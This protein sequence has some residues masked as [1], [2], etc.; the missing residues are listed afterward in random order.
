MGL[1]TCCFRAFIYR[2]LPHYLLGKSCF[3]LV[4]F[5]CF[6]SI[7]LSASTWVPVFDDYWGSPG[8]WQDG[9]VPGIVGNELV[10]AIFPSPIPPIGS[11]VY[12]RQG[13]AA[14]DVGLSSIVFH[15]GYTLLPYLGNGQISAPAAGTLT[16][17]V[18]SQ[19]HP[20]INANMVFDS[21]QSLNL[22]IGNGSS[23]KL[24]GVS[25]LTNTSLS[26]TGSGELMITGSVENISGAL[27]ALTLDV[28]G[29]NIQVASSGMISCSNTNNNNANATLTIENSTLSLVDSGQLNCTT[30]FKQG[31]ALLHIASSDVSIAD[32][33]KISCN[34]V[35]SGGNTNVSLQIDNSTITMNDSSLIEVISGG[36]VG[37]V[38]I[39][40]NDSVLNINSGTISNTYNFV[41]D[42]NGL[43]SFNQSTLNVGTGVISCIGSENLGSG[44]EISFLDSSVSCTETL[45][46]TCNS[47]AAND[48][49]F[50]M[51]Q[52]TISIPSGSIQVIN[53]QGGTG[54]GNSIFLIQNNSTLSMDFGTI[55]S[56][57]SS[58]GGNSNIQVYNS[59]LN[60][61]AVSITQNTNVGGPGAAV[62]DIQSSTIG[63]NSGSI[64]ISST[65][66]SGIP[67]FN[68]QN[69]TMNLFSG[70]IN[71]A[72]SNAGGAPLA[73][74]ITNAQI[75]FPSGGIGV[76]AN[77]NNQSDI[78]LTVSQSIFEIGSGN[79]SSSNSGNGNA[80]FLT[81]TESNFN[82]ENG[83]INCSYVDN[84]LTQNAAE[85]AINSSSVNIGS[86]GVFCENT[87]DG[88]GE[89]TLTIG[90]ST[91]EI[92][93]GDLSCF[94]S[95]MDGPCSADFGIGQSTISIGSGDITSSIQNTG[96]GGLAQLDIFEST[97]TI[98][99]GN[100][101][102]SQ[103]SNAPC[104]V[105]LDIG[106]TTLSIGSGSIQCVNEGQTTNPANLSID[107]SNI[108]LNSGGI[109]CQSAVDSATLS[110]TKSQLQL[111]GSGV[112]SNP[113]DASSTFSISNSDV[114]LSGLA[115]ITASHSLGIS[116]GQ[117]SNGGIVQCLNG[118]ILI[119]NG[120]SIFNS[121]D[122]ENLAG[123]ITL[124][125]SFLSTSGN[126]VASTTYTQTAL[127]T[128]EVSITTNQ[129]H[130]L[131]SASNVALDGS[132][133]IDFNM[134]NLIN[135][136]P[137]PVVTSTNNFTSRF[138]SHQFIDTPSYLTPYLFYSPNEVLVLTTSSPVIAKTNLFNTIAIFEQNLRLQRQMTHLHVRMK[139]DID[140]LSLLARL[141]E[142][143]TCLVENEEISSP[144]PTSSVLA[145]Q[146]PSEQLV[147]RVKTLPDKPF[148]IY[149]GPIGSV[150]HVK[151][152]HGQ[153]GNSFYSLGVLGGFDYGCME[154]SPWPIGFGI[155]SSC[156]YLYDHSRV[157]QNQGSFRI[158]YVHGN[159]YAIAIPKSLPN[160]SLN[161]A[162]GFGY[163]WVQIDRN[164]GT[165]SSPQQAKGKT[166]GPEWDALFGLEYIIADDATL[167]HPRGLR[168]VFPVVNVQYAHNSLGGYQEKGAGIYNLSVERQKWSALWTFAGTRWSYLFSPSKNVRL[169]PEVS[170]GWQRQWNHLDQGLSFSS[171]EAPFPQAFSVSMKGPEKNSLIFGFDF[172]CQFY[173]SMFIE[174]DYDLV[175]NSNF[176]DNAFYL[177]Y[178]YMF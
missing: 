42:N 72:Y 53:G 75:R 62:F 119:Q 1:R 174:L 142:L 57:N 153:A 36:D 132:L 156:S 155:G 39:V 121:G 3:S 157:D 98:N 76:G 163:E 40:V 127:S 115:G 101:S 143:D 131:V 84:S 27:T 125:N 23:L 112:I 167:N 65:S 11:N 109:L 35:V 24:S 123:D 146:R 13:I 19:A 44:T 78:Q 97:V 7:H 58:Q 145:Q 159:I 154:D 68:I 134:P 122:F 151:K 140:P 43:I 108:T 30:G 148:S 41:P 162:L 49:L 70:G 32:S 161:G 5:G 150:G 87:S 22:S 55:V 116:G 126:V 176:I 177:Q 80:A 103:T 106:K 85:L 164:T 33:G 149:L 92:D 152:T 111:N 14:L 170:F 138:S 29:E 20:E 54:G 133:L 158:D 2:S 141:E 45:A 83:S 169:R 129:E 99:S 130:G 136:E 46:M 47:F 71:Y 139:H 120:A 59:T 166:R 172:N 28:S 113:G 88:S 64:N 51:D 82:I 10:P 18:D 165:A 25:E 168:L 89:S 66:L 34:N 17:T 147:D 104:Q 26:Q 175:Y 52:S 135:G 73:G 105:M 114:S 16:I 79:V 95:S 171:F 48:A 6:F 107:Q 15:N 94:A 178:E 96:N 81:L 56:S 86:G 124:S 63:L 38:S 77:A 31:N 137:I 61:G 110:I 8:N 100:C 9:P 90:S 144:A 50:E 173:E 69:S 91:V 102:S 117:L 60:L 93:S 12:M 67:T 160:L 21:T 128:L 118:S 74:S 4:L 37:T